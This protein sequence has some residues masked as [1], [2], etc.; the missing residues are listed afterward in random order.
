[1][2]SVL[3]DWVAEMP[4]KCQSILLSGLR[5]TDDG[6]PP[7]IKAVS[8]W[9]RALAQHNADPDKGYMRPDGLPSREQL[10]EELEYRTCHFVHHFAD[11][12][13]CVSIW[14]PDVTAQET[15]WKYHYF[16]AEELFHFRPETVQEFV[17]RHRDQVAH[18]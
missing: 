18:A 6:A 5:G 8:R 9:M 16:I 1:M 12:L 3:Q 17:L 7:A 2:S 11:A 4:W 15:A 10:C 14:H 13:R